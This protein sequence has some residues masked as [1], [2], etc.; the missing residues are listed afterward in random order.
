MINESWAWLLSNYPRANRALGRVTTNKALAII[1]R[2]YE[3][4]PIYNVDGDFRAWLKKMSSTLTAELR[5]ELNADGTAGPNGVVSDFLSLRTL[6]GFYMDPISIP[7]TDNTIIRDE[8]G[9]TTGFVSARHEEIWN[10]LAS[11]MFGTPRPA[12]LHVRKAA[13]TGFPFSS[14]DLGL[15]SQLLRHVFSNATR[16]MEKTLAGRLESLAREDAIFNAF[17]IGKR[18]QAD[19]VSFKDGRYKSK[20]REVND[21]LYSRSGGAEGRR[22]IASKKVV[23]DGSEIPGLF[24]MRQRTVFGAPFQTNHLLAAVFSQFREFYLNEF[25]FTWKHRGKE[26]LTEKVAKYP[27]ALGLD[28]KQFDQSV[29]GWMLD[30]MLSRL[31]TRPIFRDFAKL[32]RH[33]PFA[34]PNPR[35]GAPPMPIEESLF[36]DPW[37][38]RTW[39][40]EPGLPS[41]VSWNPDAG[42]YCMTATYLCLIDDYFHDVLEFGL[43]D[44]LKGKHP[45]YALLDASDDGMLLFDDAKFGDYVRDRCAN[46]QAEYF[47]FELETGVK[48]LGNVYHTDIRGNRSFVPDILTY[49]TNLYVPEH[50]LPRKPGEGFHRPFAAFGYFERQHLYSQAPSFQTAFTIADDLSRTILKEPL[51]ARWE[52]ERRMTPLPEQDVRTVQDLEALLDPSAIYKGRFQLEDLSP[53]VQEK[54]TSV[55][56]YETLKP[57]L[58]EVL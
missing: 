35:L 36:G 32:T 31:S 5:P 3:S 27:F 1:P 28:V 4:S 45:R 52:A 49:F 20:D 15:K 33:M 50:G 48:F 9:L 22:F 43:P 53:S 42:K 44:I 14:S 10:R 39:T 16:I 54:L 23:I 55:V 18:D 57:F 46:Q 21:A 56:P 13:S 26:H 11:E 8:L 29:A 2:G 17:L 38:L 40:L 25:E 7:M 6:A 37:D 19:K 58:D 34:Q 41:G 24:A 51:N 47:R 30:F 12:S